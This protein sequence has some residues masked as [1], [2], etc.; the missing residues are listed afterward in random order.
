MATMH[1]KLAE[2]QWDAE[3]SRQE[4]TGG[5]SWSLDASRQYIDVTAMGDTWATF[6]PVFADWTASVT[7]DLQLA[8]SDIGLIPGDPN[9]V[10]DVPAYIE[11]Y[12][13]ADTGAYKMLY[14][15]CICSGLS[16]NADAAGKPGITY[17]FQGAD[18]LLAYYSGA[19]RKTY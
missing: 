10:G 16:I 19:S 17:E 14:G 12:F 4:L 18:S 5:Q 9:G 11:L 7:C 6:L 2:I 3:V 8:G 1:G 15:E 13:E